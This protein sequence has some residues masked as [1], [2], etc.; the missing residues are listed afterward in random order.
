MPYIT[1]QISSREPELHTGNITRGGHRKTECLST[2]SQ[3]G[4]LWLGLSSFIKTITLILALYYSQSIY[5]CP[6]FVK[7]YQPIHLVIVTTRFLQPAH[8][9]ISNGVQ[10]Q[11]VLASRPYSHRAQHL[12]NCCKPKGV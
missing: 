9:S 12:A 8:M 4:Y 3:Q 5:V 2:G 6:A 11:S 10:T 1:G 7:L